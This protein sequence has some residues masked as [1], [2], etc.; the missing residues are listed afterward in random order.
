MFMLITCFILCFIISI[1]II[2]SSSSTIL[3][4][5]RFSVAVARAYP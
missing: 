2:S 3:V 4:L 5:E 1:I